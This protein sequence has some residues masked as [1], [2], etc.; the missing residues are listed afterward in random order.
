[1]DAI[2]ELRDEHV[3][4][5]QTADEV[6]RALRDG[7]RPTVLVHLTGLVSSLSRHVEREEAGIFTAL[8]EHGE[9][10]EEV[11]SLEG[12]HVSLDT[13]IAALDP[14]GDGFDDAVSRL[15]DELDVHI[16]RED[17]GIF[18][19]SVVTLGASG[20]ETVERAHADHPSNLSERT[21]R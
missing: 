2:T 15:L 20:W 19:V 7:D 9:F 13:A 21:T 16:E 12:E 6:R 8:R 4:L 18:P 10:A 17:L 1:M 5:T 3:A 11:A 14:E